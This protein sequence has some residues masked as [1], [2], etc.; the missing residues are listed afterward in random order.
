MASSIGVKFLKPLLPSSQTY[1]QKTKRVWPQDL[2][3]VRTLE[4]RVDTTVLAFDP[5]TEVRGPFFVCELRYI[6]TY[7]VFH[8]IPHTL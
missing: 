1:K 8:V 3:L 7:P 2:E 6:S 4:V 5:L